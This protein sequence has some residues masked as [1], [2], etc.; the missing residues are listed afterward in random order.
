MKSP[1]CPEVGRGAVSN[2]PSRYLAHRIDADYRHE[3]PERDALNVPRRPTRL[4]RETA[5]SIVSRNQSPDVPFAQSINPYR[6]CEHGCIYCFARPSH[7]RLGLSPGLDFE[8]EIYWKPEAATLLDE[9]FR[10][11]G[12]Q[13]QTIHLGAN[14]DP[15]Q[16][17]E[18]RL[19]VTRSLLE[20]FL[21]A[22]HPVT[23]L[24]KGAL[25]ERDVDLLA[26]L[27][28]HRLTRVAFSVTTLDDRLKGALEPRAAS[29]RA[30]LR[31]MR[32]LAQA[33]V[34][35]SV[36]VAPVIP[37]IT[38]GELED[39]LAAARDAGATRAGWI[40]L[41]LPLEVDPLMREWLEAHFPERV[42]AVYSALEA[43]HGGRAY[44][45][46]FHHRQTGTGAYSALIQRRFEVATRRLGY[47]RGAPDDLDTG[48]FRR[49]SSGGQLSLL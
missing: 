3:D 30:R 42:R 32:L 34:P 49:P 16:P 4:H 23:V 6:G 5:R 1:L 39:L 10:R 38:D 35:V 25:I 21:A 44:D 29:A 7:A 17:V 48:A 15:Y 20:R 40:L 26:E 43:A 14:T 27:A 33:G 37:R 19:R 28:R 8:S 36:M 45:S 11:P 13:P 41:R 47:Q 9:A 12:Y 22:R 31:A 2:P 46:R 24:T 18:K